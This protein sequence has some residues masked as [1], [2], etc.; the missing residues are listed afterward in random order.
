MT[1]EDVVMNA[2]YQMADDGILDANTVCDRVYATKVGGL[3]YSSNS[4][5]D[6][7]DE[8]KYLNRITSDFI[9]RFSVIKCK[10][11]VYYRH[12]MIANYSGDTHNVILTIVSSNGKKYKY[13]SYVLWNKFSGFINTEYLVSHNAL[14]RY[15]C[16]TPEYVKRELDII[17]V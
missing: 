10:V 2:R 16:T 17:W 3:A 4:R 6:W 5:H 14:K 13:Y 9:Q 8:A 1:L 12:N 7:D 11:P 15:K